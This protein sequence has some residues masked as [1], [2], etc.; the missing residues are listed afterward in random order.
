MTGQ[1][2]GGVDDGLAQVGFVDGFGRDRHSV[3]L[4][5]VAATWYGLTPLAERLATTSMEE[6][7]FEVFGLMIGELEPRWW[8][9]GVGLGGFEAVFRQIQ[10]AHLDGWFDYAHND[11]LQW[12]LETGLVGAI[13]LILAGMSLW[14]N[15]RLD[16]E[17]LPLYAGLA[18]L[19]LVALGDFSWHIPATQVVLAAY[20]GVLLRP[21]KD[22]EC[23]AVDVQRRRGRSSAVAQISARSLHEDRR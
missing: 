18:A 2:G 23:S 22:R 4:S 12:L 21:V 11:I 13:L 15:A 17:T 10:P 19:V 1:I 8:I 14:R 7:R 3:W 9:T 16:G 6:S 20:L 5:L